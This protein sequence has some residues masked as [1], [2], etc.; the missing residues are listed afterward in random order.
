MDT[1]ATGSTLAHAAAQEGN[2]VVLE[3]LIAENKAL[4]SQTDSNGWQPI[5]EGARA[6]HQEVVEVLIKHGANKDART[7]GGLGGTPLWLVEKEQGSDHP[8]AK[9]LRSIGANSIG[10]EL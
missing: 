8:L 10:P 9:F 3:T 1:F 6:G 5:H 7:S 2:A 4:V